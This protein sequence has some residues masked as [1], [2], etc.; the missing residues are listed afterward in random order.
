MSGPRPPALARLLLRA[1]VPDPPGRDLRADLEEEYAERLR[2]ERGRWAADL[3]YWRQ[4]VGCLV[5]LWRRR[6]ESGGWRR[7]EGGPGLA[8][9]K[10]DLRGALRRLRR[11]PAFAGLVILTLAVGIGA[12]TAIFSVLRGVLIRPLPY[13]EADRLVRLWETN[14]EVDDAR[15]GPSPL[16]F[17]DWERSVGSFESMAAW[18]LTSGTYRTEAWAEELRSAQVTSD[19]FRVLGV[20]PALGRDFRREEVV[21]YGPVMLSHRVWRRL[22]GGDP[23]V[24]GTTI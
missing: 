8:G 4:A 3:W 21:R 2:P 1:L 10:A 7:W 6:L 5:P 15:H 24:V 16:N 13:P 18:Y 9:W 20:R 14:P 19:F 17:A 12:N 23:S 11:A 22:F